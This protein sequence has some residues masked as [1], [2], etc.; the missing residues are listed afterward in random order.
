M[1]LDG[2]RS[3][4]MQASHESATTRQRMI[5]SNVVER[6]RCTQ[7]LPRH[8]HS[9]VSVPASGFASLHL[10]SRTIPLFC[11]PIPY[12][13]K[14]ATRHGCYK[15]CS[16]CVQATNFGA[17]RLTSA[18]RS[19]N[20]PVRQTRAGC[21]VTVDTHRRLSERCSNSYIPMAGEAAECKVWLLADSGHIF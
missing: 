8:T 14:P 11:V 20:A 3:L 5:L 10:P 9:T 7:N 17:I 15:K 12:I 13:L 1:W 18:D 16:T 4:H 19:V 21:S 2:S 6:P